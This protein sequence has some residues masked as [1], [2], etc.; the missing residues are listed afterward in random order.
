ML[1]ITRVVLLVLCCVVGAA[2]GAV[3]SPPPPSPPLPSPP[4][5]SSPPSFLSPSPPSLPPS[6]PPPSPPASKWWSGPFA[7]VG[8][9]VLL[10]LAVCCAGGETLG[11]WLG[12]KDGDN[13]DS[14]AQKNPSTSQN[15]GLTKVAKIPMLSF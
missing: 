5:L 2:R 14:T 15:V 11:K 10:V 13:S 12:P 6:F 8:T 3:S 9:I 4:P 7:T 1:I